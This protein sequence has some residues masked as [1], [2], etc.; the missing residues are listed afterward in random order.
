MIGRENQIAVQSTPPDW[1]LSLSIFLCG[2]VDNNQTTTSH[3]KVP[4]TPQISPLYP[5]NLQ[6]KLFKIT[7]SSTSCIKDSQTDD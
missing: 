1:I 5:D 7:I 6:A 3:N 4:P 2:I